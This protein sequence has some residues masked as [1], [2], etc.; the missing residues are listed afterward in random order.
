MKSTANYLARLLCRRLRLRVSEGSPM[1][2][3]CPGKHTRRRITLCCDLQLTRKTQLI[4]IKIN[5]DNLFDS[6]I[7]IPGWVESR[8]RAYA[9]FVYESDVKS[10]ID[11]AV[12]SRCPGLSRPSAV[13]VILSEITARCPATHVSTSREYLTLLWE[14]KLVVVPLDC[15]D[16]AGLPAPLVQVVA[17]IFKEVEIG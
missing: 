3:F 17:K 15:L 14:G 11:S 16:M 4:E 8:T 2:N 9:Q 5:R 7:S 13:A 1:S 6:K 10:H 12:T